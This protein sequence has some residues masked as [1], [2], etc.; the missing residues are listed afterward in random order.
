MENA[1]HNGPRFFAARTARRSSHVPIQ[2]LLVSFAI[3]AVIVA[4]V[5]V[6][7][8]F[9]HKVE[10]W[11]AVKKNQPVVEQALTVE[12]DKSAVE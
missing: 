9:T 4:A 3:P 2:L 12:I 6:L 5:Y 11:Q 8:S 10:D 7:Y 1:I